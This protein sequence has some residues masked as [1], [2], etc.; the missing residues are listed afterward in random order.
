MA[1]KGK[2]TFGVVG[3]IGALAGA[4]L[5]FKLVKST[6]A[7]DDSEHLNVI[8]EQQPLREKT[9]PADLHYDPSSRKLHV[10]KV[11]QALVER[12]VDNILL[13]CF[14]SHTFVN[15]L[16]AAVDVPIINMMEGMKDYVGKRYPHVR[17]VGVL[18][19]DYVKKKELF[20]QYFSSPDYELIYPSSKVQ[21]QY[22]MPAIYGE[23]GIKAGNVT[24]KVIE[25]LDTS[26]QNLLEKGAELILPG[27]TEIP[28][29][30]DSLLLKQNFDILDPNTIY[31]HWAIGGESA[32]RSRKKSKV[33][34]IGGLG[35]SATIDLMEKI[36]KSTPAIK[37]QDHVE[38]LVE[39]HPQTPDR[40]AHLLHGGEDPLI[41]LYTCA[42]RLE[43]QG[44]DFIVIPCNTAHAFVNRI[45]PHLQIP[46]VSM[47]E[48]VADHIEQSSP[49]T[50]TV[51]L[52]A[53]SG[54][55]ATGIYHQVF[56]K[57]SIKLISPQD[58]YQEM[59]MEAI[60][61]EEGIKAGVVE[62]KPRHN[63]VATATHLIEKGAQALILGC[64]ELPLVFPGI[65]EIEIEGRNYPLLDPT[66]ILARKCVRLTIG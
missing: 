27:F 6:P 39:H 43:D 41:P 13:S 49:D 37:D 7:S 45:Q 4:D 33:G 40:T 57:T 66:A 11:I 55:V 42:K 30:L 31:A 65:T 1:V 22:L 3:G 15:E 58:S 8:L 35:P 29:V 28:V 52:M 18:T 16:A 21:E 5:L 61:G 44:A 51:G 60:Y 23:K 25:D 26:C 50:Q 63:L 47:I 34:I 46:I 64:T 12:R 10:F 2:K 59:V 53:T 24:G 56:G 48:A 20:E 9:L 32:A 38:M 36:I 19:S 54:T 14:I 62:G 17:K